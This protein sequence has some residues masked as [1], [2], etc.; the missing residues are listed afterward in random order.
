MLTPIE[1]RYVDAHPKCADLYATSKDLFPNGVTHDARNLQP[2]PYFVSHAQGARKWDVDGHE[3]ID[4]KGGHGALILGHNHPDIVAAVTEQMTKGTHYAA[5]TE[6]EIDWANRVRELIPCSEK[7]R[8]HSSGTE[9]TLMAIR[10]ARSYTGK[11][12]IVKF[13]DHFHGWHDYLLA[14]GQGGVPEEVKATVTTLPINDISVVEEVLRADDVAAVIL[15]PTGA[16]M[17]Q[18]PVRPSFLS[19]LRELTERLGVVLIF[20]EV[21]TGFRTSKGGAQGYY[22]I[23]PDMCTLAKILGGGL[24]GGAVTGKA[25]IIDMV[26]LRDDAEFNATR[27]VGHNGTFNANP[28]S[29]AAGSKALELLATQPINDR[30]TAAADR[31]KAGMNEVLG[32]LEIPGCAAGV[33][34]AI[35]LRLGVDHECDKEVCLLSDADQHTVEDGAR[36]HQLELAMYSNGA[37]GG[38]R[39][40]VSSV[41]TDRD[42]DETVEAVERSLVSVRGL[43][44]V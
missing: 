11:S 2:F 43:G 5:S 26:Q 21:V 25:E 19:E 40:I 24:P 29:A 9:A 44:L 33:G 10:M 12:R 20:D 22:G 18:W 42:I 3:I 13:E 34:S 32:R 15:E 1:Q 30:A 27:R 23:T 14:S 28:L 16:H 36:K 39:F 35:F 37:D 41:H 17:G 6:L 7:V 38:P 31:L 8:F 4:Y